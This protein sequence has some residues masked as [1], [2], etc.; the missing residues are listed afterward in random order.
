MMRSG[1][2]WLLAVGVLW[3]AQGCNAIPITV[4]K[5]DGSVADTA[6]VNYPD[7]R[8]TDAGPPGPD[9]AG[10]PDVWHNPPAPDAMTDGLPLVGDG[11]SDGLGDGPVGEGGLDAF[12]LDWLVPDADDSDATGDAATV[13]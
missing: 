1:W 5:D 8:G 3:V 11:Q 2:K 7:M 6:P 4:P 9:M 10:V 12:P 13:D